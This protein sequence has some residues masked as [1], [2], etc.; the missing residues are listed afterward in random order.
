MNKKI[1]VSLILGA[2]P[3]TLMAQDDDM[4]FVPSKKNV[5]KEAADY[6]VP[7]STYYSGIN[8]SV[9]DYNRRGSY[10]QVLP[11][12]T[13]GNDIIT[14]SG[15]KGV[16]PAPDSISADED[17][18]LTRQMARYD[19]YEPEQAYREGYRDGRRD[20]WHSPW[21]YSSFYPW[22][23]SYWY[24]NDPWYYGWHGAW[25]DPW[26]Y[27]YYWYRP[28]GWY[29]WHYG[30]HRPYYYGGVT[31]YGGGGGGSSKYRRYD[32]M[33]ARSPRG[34]SNGRHTTHTSGTFGGSSIR[35]GSYGS[36]SATSPGV[37]RSTGTTTTNSYGNFGGSRT[38]GG[39]SSS[40]SMGSFGGSPT[41]SSGGSFGGG[42]GG[43]FGGGGGGSFGGSRSV[44]GS[45]S[46]R[47]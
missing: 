7:R 9:D 21:Y 34:L 47:R 33:A 25:Y 43:S 30:W 38:W 37:Q 39:S 27:D 26:Y 20:S 15:T 12:D 10:Y 5:E 32:N 44:G 41:R 24:W 35:R 31:Y 28:Y 14:F 17:Y 36:R 40:G 6:G 2:L 19:G 1:L 8:R 3:L 29:R 45:R 13:T 4:Y 23:D 46:S 11:S 18:A 42:G 16:Y 22:Y